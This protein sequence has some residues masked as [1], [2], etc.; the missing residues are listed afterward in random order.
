MYRNPTPSCS[1]LIKVFPIGKGNGMSLDRFDKAEMS[2]DTDRDH[3]E[4]IAACGRFAAITPPA[5]TLLLSTS[6]T[7]EAIAKSGGGRGGGRGG[8]HWRGH[9]GGHGGGR[10]GG[11]GVGWGGGRGGHHC[12]EGSPGGAER[13]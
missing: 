11:G 12:K 1:I 5:V 4:F 9:G 7:S 8:G 6:L 3:R 10:G 2:S 13:L